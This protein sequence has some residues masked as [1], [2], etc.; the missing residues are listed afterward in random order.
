[1]C[2][3][4]ARR[5]DRWQISCAFLG[6][7]GANGNLFKQLL[8]TFK[9]P[10]DICFASVRNKKLRTHPTAKGNRHTVAFRLRIGM[11]FCDSMKNFFRRSLKI[12]VPKDSTRR[13]SGKR[14]ATPALL[15]LRRRKALTE[16]LRSGLCTLAGR[17]HLATHKAVISERP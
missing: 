5:G 1:M 8:S 17:G 16:E 11:D 7:W 9:K 4:R 6:L 15:R 10:E 14:T 3:A 12:N 13:L 2:G